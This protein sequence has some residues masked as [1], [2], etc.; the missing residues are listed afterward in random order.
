MTDVFQVITHITFEMYYLTG[1]RSGIH[2]P[3]KITEHKF[4]LKIGNMHL[5]KIGRCLKD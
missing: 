2:I 1:K 3:I 4:Q 5:T